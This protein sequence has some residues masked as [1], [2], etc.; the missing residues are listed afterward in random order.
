ME[1]FPDLEGV[2]LRPLLL[3]SHAWSA[4]EAVWLL[5]LAWNSCHTCQDEESLR[6]ALNQSVWTAMVCILT[7]IV[8]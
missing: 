3:T 2:D 8:S 5:A 4:Y 7:Y 1:M 6:A